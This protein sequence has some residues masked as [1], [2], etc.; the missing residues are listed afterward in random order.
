MYF[1]CS[2]LLSCLRWAFW[3]RSRF[4]NRLRAIARSQPGLGRCPILTH[5]WTRIRGD[6][7]ERI[8]PNTGRTATGISN[9]TRPTMT[10]YSPKGNNTGVAVAVFPGGGYQNLAIDLEA[11]AS[12]SS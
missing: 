11:L 7:A 9:V 2:V 8:P 4:G 10:V 5:F 6:H 12:A 3:D 1:C